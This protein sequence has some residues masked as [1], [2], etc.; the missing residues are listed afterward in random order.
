M[1]CAISCI[2]FFFKYDRVPDCQRTRWYGNWYNG[3][4]LTSFLCFQYLP[5]FQFRTIFG[6]T[7]NLYSFL[8]GRNFCKS[9]TFLECA[10]RWTLNLRAENERFFCT[11]INTK[12]H[13]NNIAHHVSLRSTFS[14]FCKSYYIPVGAEMTLPF[15]EP[16][17]IRR[18]G[19]SDEK[20]RAK[21]W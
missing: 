12:K 17:K 18:I 21:T 14:F 16:I 9:L 8:K 7:M 11:E 15:A 6:D 19:S 20:E 10:K 13:V 1:K 4:E 3:N 2:F 5:Y